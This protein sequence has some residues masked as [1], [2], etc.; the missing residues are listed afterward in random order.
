MRG[1]MRSILQEIVFLVALL[2]CGVS[3]CSAAAETAVGEAAPVASA[4]GAPGNR[5]VETQRPAGQVT[6]PSGRI[7]YVDLALTP[8]EQSRGYMW[9]KTITPEEGLL[10]IYDRPG[11]R[12]FWMKNCLT[13]IDI[14]WLDGDGRVITIEHSAPPCKADPCPSFGPDQP[15]FDV[16]E[17]AP[18][19]AREEGLQPGDQLSIVTDRQRP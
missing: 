13:A 17:V 4:S 11:I 5:A 14:I 18:G 2:G 3:A 1:M 10:F 12:K 19:V 9:R 6:F 7:F 8:A 15:G 16:L